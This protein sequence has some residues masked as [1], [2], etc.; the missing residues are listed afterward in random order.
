MSL[1]VVMIVVCV[2]LSLILSYMSFTREKPS[3][4]ATTTSGSVIPLHAL[5]EPVITNKSLLSW[6]SV[7]ARTAYNLDF[8]HYKTQMKAASINFSESGWEQFEAAMGKAGLLSSVKNK[9]LIMSAVVSGAP[10]IL[11]S[12]VYHGRYI[13]RIQMPMLVTFSSA[14]ESTHT[15]LLIS[16]DVARVAS[17]DAPQGIQIIDFHSQSADY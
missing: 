1:L 16:M 9:K 13:W 8:V 3:Y 15:N 12:S 5:D 7:A 2:G 4:F 14:N 10:V 17:L 11:D 6:A